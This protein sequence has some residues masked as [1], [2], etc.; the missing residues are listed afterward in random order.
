MAAAAELFHRHGVAATSL[1]EVRAVTAT[2]KSQLYHYFG[3]KAA[4]VRGVVEYQAGAV[5][6]AQQPELDA[7]CDMESLRAWAAK[8]IELNQRASASGGCPLGRL[9][10]ELAGADP[11]TQRALLDAFG[12][13]Q[14]RLSR[15]LAA[16]M[17]DR[18]TRR[19]DAEQLAAGLLSAV[20]GGLLLAQATGRREPLEAALAVALDGVEAALT[21]H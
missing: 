21:H 5:L 3:D 1:D 15:G 18:P 12:V 11:D 14:G 6:A 17:A 19:A 10:S 20:Q 2:S 9:S 13:W 7:I 8:V 16:T 4:L